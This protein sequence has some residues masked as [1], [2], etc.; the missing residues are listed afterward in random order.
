VFTDPQPEADVAR[1]GV[2]RL[3][4]AHV[5]EHPFD[6]ASCAFQQMLSRQQRAVQLALGEDAISH[7]DRC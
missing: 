1:W 2:L 4:S 5:L 6:R 7:R 3:Q